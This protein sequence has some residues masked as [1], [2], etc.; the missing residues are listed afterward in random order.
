METLTKIIK[1][2]KNHLSVVKIKSKYLIEENSSFQP[3]SVKN[4]ESVIKN[5][6][7]NKTS[8]GDIPIQMLKQSGFTY[9]ILTDCINDVIITK[10]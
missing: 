9:H 6:P 3:V 10:A 5:I 4:V 7:S 8:G 1:K 2:F